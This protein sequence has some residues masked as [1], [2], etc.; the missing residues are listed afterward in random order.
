M[1]SEVTAAIIA[2]ALTLIGTVAAQLIGRNTTNRETQAALA[3]QTFELEGRLAEQR[4]LILNQPFAT[5]AGR[6]GSEPSTVRLVG[7]YAMAGL[8]DDWT[9]NR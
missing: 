4:S 2:G 6:L 7:V 1:N 5:A 8:A 3:R 9:E